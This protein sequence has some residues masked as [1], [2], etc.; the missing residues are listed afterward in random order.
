MSKRRL[1]TFCSTYVY[2]TNSV[3]AL[4]TA[5]LLAVHNEVSRKASGGFRK[6][7]FAQHSYR[8]TTLFFSTF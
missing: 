4:P 5:F 3:D 1:F 2:S 7:F 6:S 8:L